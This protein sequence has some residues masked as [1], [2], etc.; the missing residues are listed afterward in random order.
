[1]PQGFYLR[2]FGEEAVASDVESVSVALNRSRDPPD[3]VVCFQDGAVHATFFEF[4]GCGQSC[5]ACPN[6]KNSRF[7]RR[8]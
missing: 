3:D 6:N 5:G 4:E 7:G 1:M 8:G 2:N